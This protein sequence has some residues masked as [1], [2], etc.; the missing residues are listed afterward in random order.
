MLKHPDYFHL[1]KILRSHGL[2]GNLICVF[3]TDK[4]ESYSKLESVLLER[5]NSLLPYFV[6]KV[7]LKGHEVHL[8]LEGIDTAE[9][10]SVLKGC[11]IY[12]PLNKLPKRSKNEF[13]IHDLLGCNLTD[14]NLGELGTVEDV[15]ETAGQNL[16][17][18]NYKG[19]EILLPFVKE[20]V[21]NVDIQGKAVSTNIPEGLIDIYT[22]PSKHQKDD[23]LEEESE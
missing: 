23:A 21:I 16:L 11:D 9:K 20:F 15:I 6:K 8:L 10:A 7:T 1:G 5:N 14:I 18:F 22:Q 17:S 4:P 13:Y 19:A 3:D 12:L 2:T